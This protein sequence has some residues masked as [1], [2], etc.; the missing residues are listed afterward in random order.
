MMHAVLKLVPLWAVMA[1]CC[2]LGS[3]EIR[4]QEHEEHEAQHEEAHEHHAN[5]LGL[6]LGRT[7]EGREDDFTMGLE[8]ERRINESFGVGLLVEHVFGDLDFW[9]YGVPFALHKDA[10]KF[11]VAPAIEDGEHGSE[12]L[13]RLG[14]E[15]AFELEGGWEISPQLNLDFVDSEEVWV[16]G[17]VIGKG[18]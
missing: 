7:F 12:F 2:L 18:F 1:F 4:A 9:I 13:A 10:W 5:T 15:Y 8:Y 17:V 6:F 3:G 14:A 16:L 11:Y